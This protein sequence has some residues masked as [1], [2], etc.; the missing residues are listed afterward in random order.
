MAGIGLTVKRHLMAGS[1]AP[2]FLP[3]MNPTARVLMG[4]PLDPALLKACGVREPIRIRR[5]VEAHCE[6]DTSANHRVF[7]SLSPPHL[8]RE[9]L[10]QNLEV[11]KLE[12]RLAGHKP[13]IPLPSP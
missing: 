9:G 4:C 8:L 6:V 3:S 13:D 10:L 1:N 5:P 12:V 11:A 7:F 2:P